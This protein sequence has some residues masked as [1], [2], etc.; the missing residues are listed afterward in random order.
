MYYTLLILFLYIHGI[1]FAS[2]LGKRLHF[3]VG[4]ELFQ[5]QYNEQR[6]EFDDYSSL[7]RPIENSLSRISWTLSYRLLEDYP[8]YAGIKTN[9]GFNMS[10][11]TDATDTVLNQDVKVDTKSNADTVFLAMGVHKRILPFV[12]AT[13][14]ELDTKIMYSVGL[15]IRSQN[16]YML[17]GG[18]FTFVIN[19]KNLLSFTY[20]PANKDFNMKR[21]FGVSYNYLLI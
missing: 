12:V 4:T 15:T 21:M 8:L 1:A 5:A 17:Y 18:G 19:P 7:K 11:S 2:D 13:R 6:Y 3:G 16:N 14:L 9:R 20:Y 10:V